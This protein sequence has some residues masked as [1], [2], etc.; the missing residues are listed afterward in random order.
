[1][2][3]KTKK[4]PSWSSFMSFFRF[5]IAREIPVCPGD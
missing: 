2:D 5:E 1:M 3:R 4:P